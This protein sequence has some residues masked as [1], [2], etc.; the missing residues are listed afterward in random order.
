MTKLL[1]SVGLIGLL[2]GLL[3]SWGWHY[4]QRNWPRRPR[5]LTR[6]GVRRRRTRNK[7][8]TADEVTVDE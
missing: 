4:L 2:L 8:V 5:Y 7:K 1:L 6:L 3:S